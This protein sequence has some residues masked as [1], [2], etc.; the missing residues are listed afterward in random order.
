MDGRGQVNSDCGQVDLECDTL[1]R[2]K[3]KNTDLE[4]DTLTQPRKKNTKPLQFFKPM[5]PNPRF[6][7]QVGLS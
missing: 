5:T 3:K 2:P 4:C 6:I 7:I 1:M